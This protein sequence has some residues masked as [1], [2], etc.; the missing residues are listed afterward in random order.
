MLR[1]NCFWIVLCASLTGPLVF[2]Q[3]AKP[4]STERVLIGILDDAREEMVNWKPRCRLATESSGL[5]LRRQRRDGTRLNHPRS[6]LKSIGLSLLTG[7]AS[8]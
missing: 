8:D 6:P 4:A 2:A 3:T 1:G 5:R 7:G